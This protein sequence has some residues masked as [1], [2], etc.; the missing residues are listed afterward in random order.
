MK[1]KCLMRKSSILQKIETQIDLTNDYMKWLYGSR[2]W[3]RWNEGTA[4]NLTDSTLREV[5][6]NEMMKC[7]HIGLLCVQESVY[8]RPTMAS[9]IHMLNSNSVTLPAPSKPGFFMQSSYVLE[10]S[11]S[12]SSYCY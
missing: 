1:Y 9:V 12:L 5:S 7:I 6:R 8:D 3:K 10:L 2:A 4:L 11:S